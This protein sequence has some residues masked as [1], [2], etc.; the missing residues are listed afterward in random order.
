MIPRNLTAS[1]INVQAHLLKYKIY[2][3]QQGKIY[4]AW[5]WYSSEHTNHRHTKKQENMT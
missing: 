2:S 4:N 3:I 1:K 5:H